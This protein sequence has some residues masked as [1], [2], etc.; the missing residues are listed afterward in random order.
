MADFMNSSCAIASCRKMLLRQHDRVHSDKIASTVRNSNRFG[1]KPQFTI[2]RENEEVQCAPVT[3]MKL[4]QQRNI[5]PIGGI[6]Q[7]PFFDGCIYLTR[8][9][10][11][12]VDGCLGCIVAV[13]RD[14]CITESIIKH[15]QLCS[16]LPVLYSDQ[17]GLRHAQYMLVK[18]RSAH[19]DFKEGLDVAHS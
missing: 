9:D 14:A 2:E 15:F 1:G 8:A 7:S 18:L 4:I 10:I 6:F 11:C 19:A 16:Q 17:S 5:S 12:L 13:E 3:L